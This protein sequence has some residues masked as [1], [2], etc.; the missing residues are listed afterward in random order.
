MQIPKVNYGQSQFQDSFFVAGAQLTGFRKLRQILLEIRSI[1]DALKN[2][3]FEERRNVYKLKGLYKSRENDE[4]EIDAINY[5]MSR[6]VELRED[7]ELRLDQ[8][9][10]MR[11]QVIMDYP[12][13]YWDAGYESAEIEHWPMYYG[14]KMALEIAA[15]G[16]CSISTAEQINLLPPELK[17]KALGVKN[18]ELKLLVAPQ[19]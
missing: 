13:D 18:D 12:Q 15:T 10:I 6:S 11:E 7:A 3:E 5:A 2:F 4:I 16:Q 8:F 1:E 14:K 9:L 19:E 17:L